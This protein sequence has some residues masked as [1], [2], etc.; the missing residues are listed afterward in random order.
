MVTTTHDAL[1]LTTQGPFLGPGPIS[2]TKAPTPPPSPRPSSYTGTP[3]PHT[4]THMFR[5]VHYEACMVGKWSIGILL[6]CFSVFIV[7]KCSF[8]PNELEAKA[9]IF[10]DVGHLFFGHFY[11]FLDPP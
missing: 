8:T 10:L 7:R 4:H 1:G 5:L 9:K 11:S 3:P 6:E 2:R